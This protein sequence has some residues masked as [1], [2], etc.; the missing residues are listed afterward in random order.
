MPRIAWLTDLHLN[1]LSPAEVARFIERVHQAAPDAVL[2]GGDVGH[3]NTVLGYLKQLDDT[4]A[5]PVYFVLGNHD[6]YE[7][8][9]GETREAVAA[10]SRRSRHTTWLPHAGVVEL[11]PGACLVGHDGWGDG[12]C[13]DFFG[14]DVILSDQVLIREFL[15]L[16]RQALYRKLNELGDEA[17][18]FFREVLPGALKRHQH[19]IVLTHV[20]PFHEAAWFQGRVSTTDYAPYFV[21]VAVGEVLKRIMMEHPRRTMSVL[22]GHTHEKAGAIVL[23]NLAV[24]TGGAVYGAPKIQEF[25]TIR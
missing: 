16:G 14:S 23:D 10:W 12:R 24:K 11:S 19:V 9:I 15:G 17:A 6:F 1:F 20:P 7:G 25:L 8:S 21:C 13:G 4:L 22:C 3:S 2:L 5:C 18:A